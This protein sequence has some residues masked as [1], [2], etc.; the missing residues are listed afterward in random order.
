MGQPALADG[1]HMGN[2]LRTAD[3]SDAQLVEQTRAGSDSAFEAV[4]DRYARGILGFCRHMLGSTEEAEDAVQQTFAAAW[5]AL[6][7]RDDREIALRPWLYTIARNR[8]MSML[9]SRRVTLDERLEAVGGDVSEVVERRAELRELLRDLGDLPEDQRAA[10]LLSELGDLS[11]I[12]VANV[13]GCEV[14]RVKALVFRARS[15]LIAR[16]DARVRPCEEVR[17]QIATLRGPALRRAELQLHIDEC[18]GCRAFRDSVRHQR[19][20]FAAALPV[21]PALHL[22]SSVMS[23]AGI[24]AGAAG[25]ALTAGTVG[26]IGSALVAKIAM[27]GALAGGSALAGG[28]LVEDVRPPNSP[29]PAHVE[30]AAAAP[31]PARWAETVRDNRPAPAAG[32]D[33][34]GRPGPSGPKERLVPAPGGTLDERGRGRGA[35]EPAGDRS[36]EPARGLSK[37]GLGTQRRAAKTRKPK[38]AESKAHARV[39][40]TRA[41]RG[42]PLRRSPAAKEQRPEVTP[43][44]RTPDPPAAN[45]R[46]QHRKSAPAP[47]PPGAGQPEAAPEPPPADARGR[48][49]QGQGQGLEALRWRSASVSCLSSISRTPGAVPGSRSTAT[50]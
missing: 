4:Y 15:G 13:L 33:R 37:R 47:A 43:G 16:R 23:A 36:R 20:L 11:H 49:G 19:H 10:L 24:G 44:A 6:R 18:Q 40:R 38:P 34:S 27:V 14:P 46:P 8:C 9:R 28:T 2:A 7:R 41:R 26:G 35:S 29:P 25:A 48:G 3:A 45:A 30:V 22:K 50:P 31:A 32:R 17:E 12:E 21:A 5:R 1:V 39:D 42:E